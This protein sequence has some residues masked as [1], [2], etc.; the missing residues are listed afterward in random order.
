ME[1]GYPGNLDIQITYAIENGNTL[2]MAYQATTDKATPVN[3][4]NHAYYNLNGK[5][6]ESINNHV[7]TIFADN[8][9][10]VDSTLIPLGTIDPVAGTPFDFTKPKAIGTDVDSANVQLK[11][12]GGY[13]HNWVLNPNADANGFRPAATVYSPLTGIQ[14]EILTQEPGIQ[15]YGGNF[16]NGTIITRDGNA[17]GYRCGLALEP[18]HYPDAVNQPNFPTTILKPGETYS[19]VSK[20]VFSLV[21]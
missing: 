16:F 3:L 14:M 12:G 9:T 5:S 21:K 6:N 4:T 1:E 11:Y 19:T 8:Y 13:D 7:L 2:T 15:F 18:Q 10:P 20:Y 17:V